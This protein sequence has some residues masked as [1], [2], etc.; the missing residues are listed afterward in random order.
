MGTVWAQAKGQDKVSQKKLSFL[1]FKLNQIKF[2]FVIFLDVQIT[3]NKMY[4]F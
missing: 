4:P 3:Y 2:I 1:K